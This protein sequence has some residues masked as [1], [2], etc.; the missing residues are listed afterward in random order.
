MFNIYQCNDN[1]TVLTIQ[2]KCVVQNIGT[3]R[4]LLRCAEKRTG[5]AAFFF[6]AAQQRSADGDMEKDSLNIE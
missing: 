2:W 1:T 3:L 5:H 4:P 6:S